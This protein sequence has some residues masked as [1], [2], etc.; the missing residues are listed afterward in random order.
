[1]TVADL[2]CIATISTLNV[3]VPIA[4]NRYPNISAWM[5]KMQALPYYSKANQVGLDK[6]AGFMKSKLA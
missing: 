6:F 1:M 5:A 4:A 3:F 2:A